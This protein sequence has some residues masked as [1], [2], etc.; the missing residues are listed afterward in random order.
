MNRESNPRGLRDFNSPLLKYNSDQISHYLQI[1]GLCLQ[2]FFR[3][4]KSTVGYNNSFKKATNAIKLSVNKSVHLEMKSVVIRHMDVGPLKIN[5]RNSHHS[6]PIER[7]EQISTVTLNFRE[8]QVKST[9]IN[10]EVPKI[11]NSSFKDIP[12]D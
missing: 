8:G 5:R 10:R 4:L 7:R 2:I 9:T 12:E 3:T 1:F 11:L 6:D